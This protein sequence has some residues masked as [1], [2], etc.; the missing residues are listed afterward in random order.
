MGTASAPLQT[1]ER[2]F[3]EL[4]S[5]LVRQ[6]SGLIRAELAL[7]ES[8]IYEKLREYGLAFS[9]AALGM[10]FGFLGLMALV[11]AGIVALAQHIGAAASAL[12]FAAILIGFAVI[13]I[14]PALILVGRF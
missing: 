1:S 11:A 10:V 3:T 12:S 4:I 7:V 14:L 9:V 2:S 13:L 5:V 6:I 8:G